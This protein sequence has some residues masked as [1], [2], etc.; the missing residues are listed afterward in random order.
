MSGAFGFRIPVATMTDAISALRTV[1]GEAKLRFSETGLQSRGV[2]PAN[3]AMV[4]VDVSDAA[5][6]RLNVGDE[7]TLGVDLWTFADVLGMAESDDD[8]IA[9]LNAG[10][11]KLELSFPGT[12]LEYTYT[13]IDPDAIRQEPDI[14]DLDLGGEFIVPGRAIDRGLSAADLVSD[15][16]RLTGVSAD[17]L[18]LSADGDTDSVD[19][20]ID[21]ALIDGE[22]TGGEQD[23]LFSLD[24]LSDITRPIGSDVPVTVDLGSEMPV[25]MH[26]ETGGGDINVTAMAA[27][28]IQ[29][30]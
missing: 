17:R 5:F 24:Y 9:R 6:K 4:D 19:L 7:T 14:P 23:S 15:H 11:R 21:D 28:R 27:P 13:L 18:R 30:S 26:F 2:D 25:K 3:V 22:L 29:G 16:I 12:G 8:L 10:T 20:E 1:V